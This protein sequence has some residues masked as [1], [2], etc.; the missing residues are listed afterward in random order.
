MPLSSAEKAEATE[1]EPI[2]PQAAEGENTC[3][4]CE[5]LKNVRTDPVSKREQLGECMEGPPQ[6]VGIFAGMK[7]SLEHPGQTDILTNVRWVWPT[8]LKRTAACGRF[9]P[10]LS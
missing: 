9:K 3:G 6:G 1:L 10:R 4:Q 8:L 7:P 5:H 2:T